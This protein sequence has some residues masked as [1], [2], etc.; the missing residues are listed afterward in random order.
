MLLVALRGDTRDTDKYVE[1]F[2]Q[3]TQFPWDP[4]AFYSAM[5]MEWGFGIASWALNCLGLGP[6]SLFFLISLGTFYFLNKAAQCAKLTLIEVAPYY[7][8]NFFLLQ[9]LMQIRQGLAMTFALYVLV[10]FAGRGSSPWRSPVKLLVSACIHLT[11]V[12]PILSAGLLSHWMP[13]AKRWCVAIWA[14]LIVVIA[15]VI[16]R[17]FMNFELIE[18]LGRLSVYASDAEY[19]DT[20]DLFDVANVRALAVLLLLIFGANTALLRSKVF[21]LMLGLYAAHFGIRIGFFDFLILSGRLSTALSFV[22]VLLLPLLMRERIT[23]QSMRL[24]FGLGYFAAHAT[25][26]LVAQAPFLINDYRAPLHADY[27]AG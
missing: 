18:D 2:L 27:T 4:M 6:R 13:R 22:E 11:S 17:A 10:L 9:Q 16:A 3:T 26:T 15:A 7:L 5:G 24:I 25:A 21:V 20:R 23:S 14:G 1:V 8:G 19:S 12:L